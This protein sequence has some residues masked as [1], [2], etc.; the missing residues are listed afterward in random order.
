MKT[1]FNVD[2]FLNV[3]REYNESVFPVQVFFYLLA[4]TAVYLTVKGNSKSNVVVSGILAFFWLW[5]GI[6]Y[7]LVFFTA[8]NKA[9][10]LF[11][12]LFI[13]QGILFLIFGALRGKLSFKFNRDKYGIAG[14]VMIFFALVMYP[15][16]GYFYGH[17]YPSSPTFGLPCPTAIFTFGVLLL[18]DKKCPAALLIIPS[19]WSIIGFSAAITLGIIEDIGLLVSGIISVLLLLLRSK[20]SM[21]SA[22]QIQHR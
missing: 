21:K 12:M 7:H 2:Q 4:I 14:I 6:V 13:L 10:Y 18:T 22:I 9:A 11:G 8:I 15:I 19:I 16:V 20:T 1:P 17:M 5:M 3:F